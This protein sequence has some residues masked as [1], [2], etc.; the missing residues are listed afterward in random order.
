MTTGWKPLARLQVHGWPPEKYCTSTWLPPLIGIPGQHLVRSAVGTPG[1]GP[2]LPGGQYRPGY[3]LVDPRPLFRFDFRD[4]AVFF[5]TRH[6][7]P[8]LARGFFQV[9]FFDAGAFEAA[10]KD[11]VE[12][13]RNIR[14]AMSAIMTGKNFFITIHFR[15]LVI[16]GSLTD[17]KSHKFTFS[18]VHLCMPGSLRNKSGGIREYWGEGTEL[19]RQIT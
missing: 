2:L 8:F 19:R 6:P 5:P 18:A 10:A 7:F 13:A 3:D 1:E 16:W 11:A 4:P 17:Y 12:P 14:P 15:E 9:C